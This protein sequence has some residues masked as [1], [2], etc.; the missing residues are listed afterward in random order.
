MNGLGAA[1]GVAVD[2]C[3]GEPPY[4]RHPVAL[5]GTAMQRIER[6]LYRDRRREGVAY[7]AVGSLL[8]AS[9]GWLLDRLGRTVGTAA[10]VTI[11]SAGRMLDDEA[12]AV[13]DLLAVGAID[14]ARAR[15]R[16]LVGRDTSD[17]DA[18]EISRAVVE[19]V[20]ENYVDAVVAPLWWGWLA[21]P[22]GACLHRTLNTMDAMVGHHSA[23]YEHFGWAAARADDLANYLPA[24][25][26]LLSV[27]AVRPTRAG[28]IVRTVRRDAPAHPSPNGG[29]IEAAFAAALGVT[30]GGNNRYGS[31]VEAR[32]R[33]GTGPLPNVETIRDAVQ[34]RRHATIAVALAVA[35]GSLRPAVDTGR[36]AQRACSLSALKHASR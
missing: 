17:L 11:C 28:A 36:S 34:L 13:A 19:S 30:L 8:G 22:I 9:A 5:F 16:S 26:A 29:V 23:R 21:G 32:G 35:L 20:A 3:L 27:M 10:A 33:L 7:L 25:L 6:R 4:P 18:S 2:Q 24:R 12:L 15:L 31:T 1:A 14:D